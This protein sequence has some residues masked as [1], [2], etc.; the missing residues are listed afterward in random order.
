MGR[1]HINSEGR[2]TGRSRM[3][4]YERCARAHLNAKFAHHVQTIGKRISSAMIVTILGLSVVET[5]YAAEWEVLRK[6]GI[7]YYVLVPK[8]HATDRKFFETTAKTICRSQRICQVMFW[9]DLKFVAT[10]P[11]YSD[12][13]LNQLAAQY[14]YN[15][16]TGL[17]E[18]LMPCRIDPNPNQCF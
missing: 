17:V 2:L 5:T 13:Q 12:A 3:T 1:M 7:T 18:L 11:P 4:L 8:A 9:T 10:Q 15:R 14:W 16:N 6:R